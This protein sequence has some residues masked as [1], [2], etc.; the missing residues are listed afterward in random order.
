MVA[1]RL[2]HRWFTQGT[3]GKDKTYGQ[4]ASVDLSFWTAM[5]REAHSRHVNCWMAVMMETC[6][7]FSAECS[8]FLS[9]I[10]NHG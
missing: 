4:A 3:C 9:K 8:D 1:F 5:S 6:G 10:C 2:E 7:N